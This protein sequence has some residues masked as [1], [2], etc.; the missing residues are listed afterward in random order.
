MGAPV[1]PADQAAVDTVLATS[2]A[3]LGD[4][5]FDALWAQTHA[6]PLEELLS[7]LPSESS[8]TPFGR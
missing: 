6:L 4:D 7:T 5:A 2:C 8:S 1:W 3:A